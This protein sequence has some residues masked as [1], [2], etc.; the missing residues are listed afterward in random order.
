MKR[1][2]TEYHDKGVEFIGVSHDVPE[3]EGGLGALKTF[4]ST[5]HIPWPQYFQGIDNQAV[6]TASPTNNFSESWGI[7]GIPTV[8][9]ID[10]EGKLYSTEAGGRLETLIPWLLETSRVSSSGP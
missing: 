4:V 10:R 5:W 8:F 3:E 2:Y 7:N 1:I 9:L 6:V